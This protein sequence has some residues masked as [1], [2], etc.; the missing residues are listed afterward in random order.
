MNEFKLLFYGAQ[1]QRREEIQ[2]VNIGNSFARPD[3]GGQYR[4]IWSEHPETREQRQVL[5][6]NHNIGRDFSLTSAYYGIRRSRNALATSLINQDFGL[7]SLQSSL[8]RFL[9]TTTGAIDRDNRNAFESGVQIPFTRGTIGVSRAWLDNFQSDVFKGNTGL[10]QT[11]DTKVLASFSSHYFLNLRLSIE[12]SFNEYLNAAD[13]SETV[14][15][16]SVRTGP[17]NW[18]NNLAFQSANKNP[19]G[20][21]ST[22]TAIGKTEFRTR[23]DYVEKIDQMTAEVQQRISQG[24][25]VLFGVTRS[26]LD[27]SDSLR[28]SGTKMFEH[29][30]TS[31]DA[32]WT[33]RGEKSLIGVL[34]YGAL[35]EPRNRSPRFLPNAQSTYGAV[36]VL[37]FIDLDGN[38][39]FNEGDAP[40]EDVRVLANAQESNFKTNS[41]GVV[42]MSE[43]PTHQL[44]H[45]AVSVKDLPDP[46]M[47]PADDGVK[48]YLRPGQVF[49][50]ELPIVVLSEI[51]GVVQTKEGKGKRNVEV[52]VTNDLGISVAK[53]RTDSEGFFVVENLSAGKYRV[54]LSNSYLQRTKLNAQPLSREV[55]IPP[56]GFNEDSTFDF[57]LS[58]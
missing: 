35:F 50:L 27:R 5:E 55:L 23:F 58:E 46:L 11:A 40:A 28:L 12:Q 47:K 25:N 4:L 51:S 57:V 24:S 22:L 56:T 3:D 13:D 7:L 41:S 48:V 53:A 49:K 36:S 38:G 2:I 15:R 44:L 1:G 30:T 54:T 26:L 17:V 42:V 6:Y 9:V 32:S 8:G 18:F 14:Q 16:T 45:F 52:E 34:S 10:I 19:V 29:F 37:I 20:E 21:L 31:L 43:L 39:V 33:T